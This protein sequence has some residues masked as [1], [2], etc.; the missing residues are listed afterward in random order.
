MKKQL[1]VLAFIVFSASANA[2]MFAQMFVN[3]E[4]AWTP[5]ELNP[6]AW[7][8][9]DNISGT[10]DLD[11]IASKS[12]TLVGTPTISAGLRGNAITTA[13]GKYG[14]FTAF[15]ATGV[16]SVSFW[17]KTATPTDNSVFLGSATSANVYVNKNTATAIRLKT[18]GTLPSFTVPSFGIDWRMVTVTCDGTNARVYLDGTISSSGAQAISTPSLAAFNQIGRFSNGTIIPWGGQIDELTFYD[19]QLTQPQ[20]TLLYNYR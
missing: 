6:I 10:E 19:Y 11:K 9:F 16:F 17:A 13:A 3:R 14:S 12:M 8:S 20:I 4:S 7:W 5:S 15:T 2:Q 18:E 1:I